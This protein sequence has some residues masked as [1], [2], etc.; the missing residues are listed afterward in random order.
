MKKLFALLLALA[1]VISCA[2]ALA[3]G[4]L[5]KVGI[6]NLDPAESGYRQANVKNLQ[7]TFTVENG[8]ELPMTYGVGMSWNHKQ[9]LTVAADVTLQKWGATAFPDYDETTRSYTSRSGLLTDR[10]RVGIGADY[11]PNALSLRS[12]L[13]RVHYRI[14]AAYA[15]PYYK[16]N[17]SD[18]PKELSFS[19]GLGLP[20]QNAWNNRS[21]LNISAQWVHTSAQDL[22]TDNSFR[23][24][25]GLTFNEK[26]FAKWRVE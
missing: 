17:G 16:I 15:T 8:L 20:L 23:I 4:E 21:V 7:D 14:G 19:A 6:I 25:V 22:I 18:G 13:H 10:T 2:A 24:S 26:W 5:I 9:K 1:M 11:I 3:E 12:Y